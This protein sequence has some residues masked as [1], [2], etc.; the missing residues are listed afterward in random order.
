MKTACSWVRDSLVPRL[1][2]GAYQESGYE[3][4]YGAGYEAGYEAGYGTMMRGETH[5]CDKWNIDT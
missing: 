1:L 5:D 4:G 2:V 3:A